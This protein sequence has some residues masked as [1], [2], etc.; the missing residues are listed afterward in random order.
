MNVD[1]VILRRSA[2][3]VV[4]GGHPALGAKE[5]L[6]MLVGGSLLAVA[7]LD[8]LLFCFSGRWLG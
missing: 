2:E 3:H 1:D 8:V 5:L 6:W 7:V 4:R